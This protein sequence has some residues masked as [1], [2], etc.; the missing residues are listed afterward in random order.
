[1][2]NS[3]AKDKM[4]TLFGEVAETTSM[5]MTLSKDIDMY[6]MSEMSDMGRTTESDGSGA[7]IEYIPQEYRFTVQDGHVSSSGDFQDLVDRMIPVRRNKSKR[8]LTQ[9]STKDL[10]DPARPQ[11][12]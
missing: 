12:S 5:N 9:I 11:R 10:R 3:F 4:H 2:A 8:I 1:M 7:D 6:D